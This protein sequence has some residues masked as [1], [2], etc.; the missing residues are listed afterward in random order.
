MENICWVFEVLNFE[1]ALEKEKRKISNWKYYLKIAI[2]F[3]RDWI[4]NLTS[5]NMSNASGR[6]RNIFGTK[7]QQRKILIWGSRFRTCPRKK[8]PM[9]LDGSGTNLERRQARKISNLKLKNYFKI[10]FSGPEFRI[11]PR[12][13]WPMPLTGLGAYLGTRGRQVRKIWNLKLKKLFENRSS[14]GSEV[15][16][17]EKYD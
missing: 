9:P 5:K 4:S 6:F 8:S 12:K 14:K 2:L 13:I 17:F 16:N 15:L 7:R 10:G 3:W 1:S 11:C